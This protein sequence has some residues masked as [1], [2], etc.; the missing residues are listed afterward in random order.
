[1]KIRPIHYANVLKV[2]IDTRSLEHNNIKKSDIYKLVNSIGTGSIEMKEFV[3]N[4]IPNDVV[5]ICYGRPNYVETGIIGY[6]ALLGD[7]SKLFFEK[8][9]SK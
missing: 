6:N 3:N 2:R 4:F 5:V 1:M 7:I 8:Y 9:L